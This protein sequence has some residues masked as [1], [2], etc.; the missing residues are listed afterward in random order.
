MHQNLS[1]HSFCVTFIHTLDAKLT[2]VS[3][4]VIMI[5]EGRK[6]ILK[7]KLAAS[8]LKPRINLEGFPRL[9]FKVPT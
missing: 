6:K 5:H 1:V 8:I 7:I 9:K 3:M 4:L 2:K